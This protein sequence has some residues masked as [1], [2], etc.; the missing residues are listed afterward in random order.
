L[1]TNCLRICQK[2][3]LFCCFML[4]LKLPVIFQLLPRFEGLLKESPLR[5]FR[6]PGGTRWERKMTE[7]HFWNTDIPRFIPGISGVVPWFS[8]VFSRF[9]HDFPVSPWACCEAGWIW[10]AAVWIMLWPLW[11]ETWQFPSQTN[12]QPGRDAE[13]SQPAAVEQEEVRK[14]FNVTHRSCH[15]DLWSLISLIKFLQWFWS[16]AC[17]QPGFTSF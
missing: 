2:N 13:P 16:F 11:K 3:Q 15:A 9:I 4:A 17:I 7:R 5:L 1:F 8:H 14:M 6:N 12:L 10:F